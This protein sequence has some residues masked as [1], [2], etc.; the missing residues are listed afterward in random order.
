MNN[1]DK[2]QRA[3][4]STLVRALSVYGEAALF[5]F[6]LMAV[7]VRGTLFYGAATPWS[8]ISKDHIQ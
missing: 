7:T 2:E 5:T 4:P 8:R 3:S 1:V 6:V